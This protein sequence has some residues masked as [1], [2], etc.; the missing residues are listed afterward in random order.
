MRVTLNREVYSDLESIMEYYVQQTG[1]QVA[2]KFYA[3]FLLCRRI[4]GERP[5]SFPVV[6]NDIRRINFHT[7]PH[8]ILFQIIDEK[9]VKILIVKHDHRDPVFGTE[10]P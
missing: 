2:A 8:H 3:E 9:V 10:R 5:K 7:F 4:I 6:R 1:S